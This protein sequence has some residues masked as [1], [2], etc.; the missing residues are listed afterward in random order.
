MQVEELERALAISRAECG[1]SSS[2]SGGGGCAQGRSV[3][4]GDCGMVAEEAVYA[5][6]TKLHR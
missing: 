4:G 5:L 3:G 1:K 2:G 6:E